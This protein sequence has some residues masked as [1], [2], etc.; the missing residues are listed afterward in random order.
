MFLLAFVFPHL[1]NFCENSLTVRQSGSLFVNQP[2]VTC[3]RLAVG[4]LI[5]ISKN[6]S[7]FLVR[8][9]SQLCQIHEVKVDLQ[10]RHAT[11]RFCRKGRE[12]RE[13]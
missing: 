5:R 8:H 11:Q 4:L 12:S 9:V 13:Q 10:R 2:S 6:L 3:G 7:Q 1:H